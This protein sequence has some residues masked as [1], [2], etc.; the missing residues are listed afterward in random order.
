MSGH[1][2]C[3]PVGKRLLTPGVLI[4]LGLM[5]VAVCIGLWRFAFGL[6]SVT[7]LDNQYPWGIWI[8][9]D[10]ATGVALA[11]SFIPARNAAKVDPTIAL[12]HE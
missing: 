8:A 5:A 4:L 1:A 12:R 3:A 9:L 7:N 10:V 2:H 6:Q 11:A